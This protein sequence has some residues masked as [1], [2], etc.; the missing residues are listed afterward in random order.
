VACNETG[1]FLAY[2]SDE[3]GFN[4]PPGLWQNDQVDIVA[5]GDSFVH[6]FCVRPDQNFVSVIRQRHPATISLGIEGNGPLVMLASLKEY[7]AA[8]K[9]RVVLWFYFEGNDE[10]DLYSE[11][12]SPL[13]RRYLTRG[14]RQGL[15][16]QQA[17]IDEALT[18][19][20]EPFVEKSPLS[21]KLE[22][23]SSAD[24]G[25]HPRILLDVLKLQTL[26][27]Q[28][29][30]IGADSS[31]PAADTLSS[32]PS[33]REQEFLSLLNDILVEAKSSTEEWGGRLYFVYLPSWTT[34]AFPND[35]NTYR[36]RVLETAR[37]V[38]LPVIDTHEVF[39]AHPDPL[40][41]FPFRVG[42]H[43]N[44]EGHRLVGQTV[45]RA[46]DEPVISLR[47]PAR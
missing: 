44:D 11:K 10:A 33:P 6:G 25:F 30:L 1:E 32:E 24:F 23:L 17:Q 35:P 20:T 40:S 41:L 39:Q 31:A 5:L 19:F 9:P 12:Q 36:G 26:R 7:A 4:N 3:H 29:G 42:H 34:Y 18:N 15:M 46:L 2:V 27:T 8:L 22:E 16:E 43:Y 38:G 45:L 14:F 28:L 47:T 21:L 37:Q 13:L